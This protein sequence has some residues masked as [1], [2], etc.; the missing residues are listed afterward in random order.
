MS[1]GRNIMFKRTLTSIPVLICGQ[2]LE[3]RWDDFSFDAHEQNF[4]KFLLTYE[5]FLLEGWFMVSILSFHFQKYALYFFA[6]CD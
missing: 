6:H 1:S 2:K 4:S 3:L 5:V